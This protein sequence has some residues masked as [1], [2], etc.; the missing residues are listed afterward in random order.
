MPHFIKLLFTFLIMI[1]LSGCITAKSIDDPKIN[2]SKDQTKSKNSHHIHFIESGITPKIYTL[3]NRNALEPAC[4]YVK[5]AHN[6]IIFYPIVGPIFDIATIA[7]SDKLLWWEFP[8]SEILPIL[9]P[10]IVTLFG[11]Q[12]CI[13]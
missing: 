3:E 13:P 7:N 8:L 4:S 10:G 6:L 2:L 5:T 12:I 9:G 1:S 11:S